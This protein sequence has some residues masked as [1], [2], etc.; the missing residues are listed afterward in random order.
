MSPDVEDHN[1]SGPTLPSEINSGNKSEVT[2]LDDC[3]EFNTMEQL[4][5]YAYENK[6]VRSPQIEITFNDKYKAIT[7]L[8]TGSEENLLSERVYMKMRKSGI[9]VCTLPLERVVLII[10][11]GRRSNKQAMVEFTVGEGKFKGVFMVS[12]RITN[13]VISGCQF[14]EEYAGSIDFKKGSLTCTTDGCVKEQAF[15]QSAEFRDVERVVQSQGHTPNSIPDPNR[16]TSAGKEGHLEP[17]VTRI[18]THPAL[19]AVTGN[20]NISERTL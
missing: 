19:P 11:F 9:D 17:S 14:L 16:N 20:I 15:H 2:G 3:H 1:V 6:L 18:S 7:I 4:V 12:P 10:A 13:D 5:L 8:D